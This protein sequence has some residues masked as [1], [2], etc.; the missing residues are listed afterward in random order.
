MLLH[1]SFKI[2]M[3]NCMWRVNW[4]VILTFYQFDCCWP[5]SPDCS[6]EES[7]VPVRGHKMAELHA[8]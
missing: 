8:R 5:L 7:P 6:D 1:L 2:I 3:N 4:C